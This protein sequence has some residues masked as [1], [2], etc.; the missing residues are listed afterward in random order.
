M[1]RIGVLENLAS[2]EQRPPRIGAFVQGLQQ[3]G[4]V[5]GRDL[6][7][8]DRSAA[9][10]PDDLRK[11]AAEFAALSPDAILAVTSP[12]VGALLSATHN[13]PV[14][15]VQVID[16]VG[17]GFVN[18]LAHPGGNATGFMLFEFSLSGKWLEL[19]KEMAP[20]IS[21][22]AV[23]R[24]PAIAAGTGQFGAIQAVASSFGVELTP[25]DVRDPAEIERGISA[26]ARGPSGGLI[27]TASPLAV[28]HHDLIVSLA[29]RY[30][31]PAVYF[32]RLFATAN[33]LISYGADVADQY[34]GAAGYVDRI[35][36]GEK[37]EDLPVQVPTKFEL[38]INLKS[39]KALGLTIPPPAL[40]GR[41]DEVI[42]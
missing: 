25:V 42:E 22:V 20:G 28:V 9:G 3:S 18:S 1:R 6:R 35:L 30:R 41:A 17:A 7:L 8:D 23:V 24:D 33:G 31:L 12:A 26:F 4:W 5:V 38:V 13:V 19:L 32:A 40:L 16:P 36:R 29:G 21:R 39:A 27:V 11:F 15:F 34:R 10:N 2:D 37:P 14:V